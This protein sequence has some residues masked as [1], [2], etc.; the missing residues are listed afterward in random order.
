M[1]M[2]VD[3]DAFER[4]LVD[5]LME[6]ELYEVIFASSGNQALGMLRK[7]RPDL[8][9]MDMDMP[10]VN[11][12][13]TLRRLKATPAYASIPVMMVTSHSEREVVVDCLRAGAVD[14]VI[15]PLDREVFL[16]KVARFLAA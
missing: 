9:L 8:I 14:F 7:E 12:L 6:R 11:G 5:K 13:D 15:K 3:D 2:V 1:V 10:E 4:K 16:G